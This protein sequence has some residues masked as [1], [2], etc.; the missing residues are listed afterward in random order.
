MTA[1]EA[2]IKVFEKRDEN[3]LFNR[4]QIA[5][6]QAVADGD[7]EVEIPYNEDKEGTN[8]LD[9]LSMD[10]FAL[11]CVKDAQSPEESTLRISWRPED[12]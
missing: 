7:F 5:I 6:K 12:D 1:K 11:T 3:D 9:L 2:R 4:A 8:G 10:R